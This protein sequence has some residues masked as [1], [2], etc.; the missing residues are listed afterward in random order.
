M[1]N[2]INKKI[3]EIIEEINRLQGI[4]YSEYNA[5]NNDPTPEEEMFRLLKNLLRDCQKQTRQEIM[6]GLNGE[7]APLLIGGDEEKEFIETL[8]IRKIK[9]LK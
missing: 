7:I 1:T 2:Y 8:I 9:N 3:K 5:M 4:E 6:R